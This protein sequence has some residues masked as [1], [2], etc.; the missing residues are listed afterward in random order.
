[1]GSV[2]VRECVCAPGCVCGRE[3]GNVRDSY[4][5]HANRERGL[6]GPHDTPRGVALCMPRRDVDAA[7]AILKWGGGGYCERRWFFITSVTVFEAFCFACQ[8]SAR[9]LFSF[10]RGTSEEC[11]VCIRY[12]L[13]S[14][15]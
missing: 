4:L 7:V 8:N 15:V 1:M 3:G 14:L 6:G 9:F 10:N 13:E 12:V 5:M 11:C 2:C